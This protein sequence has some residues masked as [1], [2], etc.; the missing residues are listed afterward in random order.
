MGGPYE[1]E[2]IP[3]YPTIGTEGPV[4][5][6]AYSATPVA[7]EEMALSAYMD[8]QDA[9]EQEVLAAAQPLGI[10]PSVPPVFPVSSA[11]SVPAGAPVQPVAPPRMAN[12]GGS[13]QWGKTT[14]T[15]T[16]LAPV[17]PELTESRNRAYQAL[18][19]SKQAEGRAIEAGARQQQGARMVYESLKEKDAAKAEAR[20]MKYLSDAEEREETRAGVRQEKRDFKVDPHRRFRNTTGLLGGLAMAIAAGA[21]AF[22]MSER[23]IGGPNP[24]M[25]MMNDLVDRDIKMQEGELENLNDQEAAITNDLG[26]LRAE[27]GDD[28]EGESELRLMRIEDF[29]G[30]LQTMKARTGSAISRANIDT[31]L[32]QVDIGFQ[33]QLI[34]EEE[35]RQARSTE[36]VTRGGSSRRGL[37]GGAAAKVEKA[38]KLPD[39]VRKDAVL[40]LQVMRLSDVARGK[41]LSGGYGPISKRWP[42]GD[43]RRIREVLIKPLLTKLGR[44]NAGGVLSDDEYNRAKT[45]LDAELT[46]PEDMGKTLGEIQKN[47]AADIAVNLQGAAAAQEGV[48]GMVKLLQRYT[49]NR[50]LPGLK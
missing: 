36:T 39:D 41:I 17:S 7:N 9:V 14:S 47:V 23:G 25:Q 12:L 6:I 38:A 37:V 2:Y 19:A 11:Q 40:G 49:K 18:A 50:P 33:N 20:R 42:A 5:A 26:M 15:T 44:M 8:R 30:L 4:P 32:A 48:P 43:Q 13:S 22:V 46:T 3:P 29:K 45:S 1:S 16:P 27:Y 24:I 28:R 31:G 34:S 10:A 35:K 21:K